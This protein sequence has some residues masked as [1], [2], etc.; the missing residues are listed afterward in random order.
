[1]R[2]L[3]KQDALQWLVLRGQPTEPIRANGTYGTRLAATASVGDHLA[4]RSYPFARG[5]ADWLSR[6]QP[7]EAVVLVAEY[8]IWASSENPRLYD[9]LLRASGHAASTVDQHPA[10]LFH[11]NERDDLVTLIQL[12]LISGWGIVAAADHYLGFT[13]DHDGHFCFLDDHQAGLDEAVRI[14]S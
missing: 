10:L 9:L 14:V 3:A 1:M 4:G 12:A 2:P 11:K 5:L 7:E 13:L 6:T 8:G